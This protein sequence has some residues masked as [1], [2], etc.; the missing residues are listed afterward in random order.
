MIKLASRQ[1][2]VKA[3]SLP[4][5]DTISP[6]VLEES[7]KPNIV[8]CV[9]IG[10]YVSVWCFKTFWVLMFSKTGKICLM[11]SL[12]ITKHHHK[13]QTYSP[14]TTPENA[15]DIRLDCQSQ[16]RFTERLGHKAFHKIFCTGC[17]RCSREKKK[18]FPLLG[19]RSRGNI[20]FSSNPST[21]VRNGYTCAPWDP[22]WS[23]LCQDTLRIYCVGSSENP[24]ISTKH[25]KR[26]N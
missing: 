8:R 17:H 5:G 23:C 24:Y 9:F 19:F 26:C 14:V 13:A 11:I 10:R 1:P 16:T 4:N 6:E 25:T 18:S 15:E 12:F 21:C 2:H 3:H 20:L 7:L 22:L